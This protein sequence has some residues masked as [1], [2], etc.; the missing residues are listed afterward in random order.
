MHRFVGCSIS[1]RRIRSPNIE[2]SLFPSRRLSLLI[3]RHPLEPRVVSPHRGTLLTQKPSAQRSPLITFRRQLFATPPLFGYYTGNFCSRHIRRWEDIFSAC[4]NTPF[5][6]A[7][8]R[9]N[10]WLKR[11]NMGT[12]SSFPETQCHLSATEFVLRWEN[13]CRDN[14]VG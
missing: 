14:H 5:V 11:A 8:N 6:Q 13:W 9:T 10:V 7:L 3:S 4:N 2:L 1:H 12:M